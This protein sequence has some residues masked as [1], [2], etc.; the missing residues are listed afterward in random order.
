MRRI[1]KILI[2]LL[3][4][5]AVLLVVNTLVVDGETKDAE[6][7]IDGGRILSLPGGDVQVYEEGAGGRPRSCSFTAIRARF[8]GGTGW[9]RSWPRI[10]A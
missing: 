2:A 9:R 6:V 8:T 10:G 1:W 4:G 7:T 5:L 3:V